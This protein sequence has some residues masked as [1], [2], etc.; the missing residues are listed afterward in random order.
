LQ[1]DLSQQL[2]DIDVQA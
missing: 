1:E 2:Q